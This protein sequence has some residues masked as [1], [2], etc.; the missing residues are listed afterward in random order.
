MRSRGD[1]E[2][3]DLR[4]KGVKKRKEDED[5]P[6]ISGVPY[7]RGSLECSGTAETKRLDTCSSTE[8]V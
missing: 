7:Q 6:N 1:D 5:L 3:D 2:F 8:A 4:A